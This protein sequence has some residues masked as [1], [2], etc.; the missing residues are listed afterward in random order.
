[1]FP[2]CMVKVSDIIV[3]LTMFS[4]PP[5]LTLH[6][7][8]PS[9]VVGIF[10]VEID[11]SAF[12]K[13]CKYGVGRRRKTRWVFGIVERGT[14]KTF[15]TYVPDRTRETLEPIIMAL[16]ETNTRIMS[17]FWRAYNNLGDRGFRHEVVN[18]SIEFVNPRTGAHTETVE[19]AWGLCKNNM[20]QFK[21]IK[22][23]DLPTFIN[24]WCFRRNFCR[25]DN[26]KDHHAIIGK[27]IAT[28]WNA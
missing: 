19:G 13:K 21:G 24:Q 3:L 14:N 17:D 23:D 2:D 18:H 7:T 28:Y 8:L 16:V 9:V 27:A 20:A 26:V 4:S 10:V 22:K 11:E 1:M 12:N 6:I 5:E 15:M 25:K